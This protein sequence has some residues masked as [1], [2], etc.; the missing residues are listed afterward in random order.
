M[1]EGCKCACVDGRAGERCESEF[2]RII[3]VDGEAEVEGCRAWPNRTI[4]TTR[5]FH[6]GRS[7]QW[8]SAC[9]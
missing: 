9:N 7:T 6:A 5:L 4:Q 8:I 2:L 1:V 3:L